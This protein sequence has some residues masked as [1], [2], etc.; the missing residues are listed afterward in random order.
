MPT[1]VVGGAASQEDGVRQYRDALSDA[2]GRDCAEAAT[3]VVHVERE[4]RADVF[5]RRALD[6]RAADRLQAYDH[7]NR[8][9][10]A[11]P[12]EVAPLLDQPAAGG[13]A[14]LIV[15]EPDDTLGWVAGQMSDHDAV[16]LVC[17]T[18]GPGVNG[19][20]WTPLIGHRA[21][22]RND[23]ELGTFADWGLSAQSTVSDLVSA[24]GMA[25]VVDGGPARMRDAVLVS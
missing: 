8:M 16:W 19:V 9:F 11:H 17:F 21:E 4:I 2:L 12:D 20:M 22:G 18:R 3:I 5:L 23:R 15:A 13:E 14:I 7:V 25:R 6:E 1:S 10:A 24:S